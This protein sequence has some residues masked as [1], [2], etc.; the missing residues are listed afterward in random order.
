[1]SYAQNLKIKNISIFGLEDS[2]IAV[3]GDDITT[4]VNID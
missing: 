2:K 1:M 4:L 3:L